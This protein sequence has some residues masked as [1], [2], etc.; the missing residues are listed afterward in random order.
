ML[1]Q[2]IAALEKECSERNREAEQLKVQRQGLQEQVKGL[3]QKT[4]EL[5][6][7]NAELRKRLLELEK[8]C[9]EL[10]RPLLCVCRAVS[11][12]DGACAARRCAPT[13]SSRGRSRRWSR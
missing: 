10:V 3:Q 12:C 5:E 1:A 9:N 13:R 4:A 8:Q 11:G 7:E 6:S 2:R